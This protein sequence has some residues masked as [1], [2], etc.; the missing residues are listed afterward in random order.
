MKVVFKKSK[1][2]LGYFT[3]SIADL[4]NDQAKQL[5]DDGFVVPSGETAI[6]SDLPEDLPGREALIKEGLITIDQVLAA[7]ETLTDIKGIG[8]KTADEILTALNPK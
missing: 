7:A 5:I 8:K 4:P 6:D 1:Q 3:G 2:G